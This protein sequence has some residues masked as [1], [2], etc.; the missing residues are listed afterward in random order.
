MWIYWPDYGYGFN[1]GYLVSSEKFK[2]T[3]RTSELEAQMLVN[4]LNGGAG[5]HISIL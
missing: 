2:V 5:K 1:I 3:F 4:Y